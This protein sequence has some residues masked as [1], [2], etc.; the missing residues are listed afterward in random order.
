MHVDHTDCLWRDGGSGTHIWQLHSYCYE[1]LVLLLPILGPV[2]SQLKAGDYIS[3]MST[4]QEYSI[5]R[6]VFEQK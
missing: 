3:C 1:L 6:S 5:A 4:S 2:V